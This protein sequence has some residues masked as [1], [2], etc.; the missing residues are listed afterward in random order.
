MDHEIG[1]WK[2]G[3]NF[4]MVQHPWSDFLRNQFIK[5]LCPS[6]GVNHMWFKRNDHAPKVNVF[7]FFL[8]ICSKRVVLKRKCV[9]SPS[10]FCFHL[11]TH[12]LESFKYSVKLLTILLS[13]LAFDFSSPKNISL[14]KIITSVLCHGPLPFSTRAPLFAYP[15]AKSIESY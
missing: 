1:P 15:T 14:R 8:N 12:L 6:L 7:I 2:D 10:H 5:P 9:F 3:L 11:A 13:S 4:S